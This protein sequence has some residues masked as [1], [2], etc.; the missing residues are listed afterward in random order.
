MPTFL[1]TMSTR[2]TPGPV[3][4]TAFSAAVQRLAARHQV[5]QVQGQLG[6][7]R[8]GRHRAQLLAQR[9]QDERIGAH[10]TLT[11]GERSELAERATQLL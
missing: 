7:V 10:V 8:V 1:A 2:Y 11:K 3:D 9:F 5:V 4:E 6:A